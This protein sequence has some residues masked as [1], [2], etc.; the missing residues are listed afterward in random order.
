MSDKDFAEYPNFAN[1]DL[2]TTSVRELYLPQPVA[3]SGLI[4]QLSNLPRWLYVA[5][6]AP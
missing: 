5:C 6:F 3:V 2:D 4:V 1:R